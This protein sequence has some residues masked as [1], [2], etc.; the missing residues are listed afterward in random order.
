[1]WQRIFCACALLQSA[2]FACSWGYLI[3]IKN[4][5]SDTPLFRFVVGQRAGYI[6]ASGKVVDPSQI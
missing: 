3:W 5:N 1:M 4:K 2:A 6:D